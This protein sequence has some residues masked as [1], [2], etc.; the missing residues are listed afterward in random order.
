MLKK[1]KAFTL[2]EVLIVIVIIGIMSIG[3]LGVLAL[4]NQSLKTH[5]ANKNILIAMQ[6]A[7]EGIELV[8]NKR[9]NNWKNNYDWD[10][11]QGAGTITDIIQDNDYAIDYSMDIYDFDNIDDADLY[12]NTDGFFT[13]F[14][15]ASST[16]FNRLIVI[17]DNT[18]A[19]TTIKCLVKW[20]D[21]NEVHNYE[22]ETILY[23]WR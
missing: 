13:H 5:Y 16:I 9:D 14:A 1:I 22:V 2:M 7:Q 6:L 23:D 20:N 3:M 17:D 10:Y 11:G 4:V 19:S 8:R 12:I 21:R 18:S 15:T